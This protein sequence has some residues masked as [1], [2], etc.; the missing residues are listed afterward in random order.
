MNEVFWREPLPSHYSP[1][2]L[3]CLHT[4]T[5]KIIDTAKREESQ[6]YLEQLTESG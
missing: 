5:I 1:E 3:L 4:E 6:E 2:G